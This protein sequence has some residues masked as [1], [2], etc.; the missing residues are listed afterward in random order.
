MSLKSLKLQ[1]MFALSLTLATVSGAQTPSPALLVLNK[2][3]RT[4][5]VVDPIS[6]RV[7]AQIP[8]DEDPHEV[9]ASADGKLAF[10]SNY[11]GTDH[12]LHT[13]SVVD[14]VA[15]KD[16]APIDL[17][18]LGAPHGM[19]FASD[20]ELYF[21]I[22][23]NQAIARYDLASHK[24]DWLLGLGQHRTHMIAVSHDLN[25]I[26]TSNVNSDTIS[27]IERD[28]GPNA[29]NETAI[30]VG[31]GPEGFDIS[32]DGGQLWAANSHDGTISVIDVNTK[33]VVETLAI[34]T[35]QA[36]RLKFTPDGKR[37]LIS[38]IHG[39]ELVVVDVAGKK[40]I[41]RFKLGSAA[42][43]ILIAPDGSRA[44]VA[45]TPDNEV[46][47]IDLR[48][49]EVTAHIETGRGPDGMAWAVR[50]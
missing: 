32:P 22:E 1:F 39:G 23:A 13:I 9:A 4:L 46:A 28:P 33:K 14:L 34:P 2:E 3:D 42:A 50:R 35:R 15:Q 18:P 45:L 31:K 8:A 24:I 17:G 47:I 21:T 27:I 12:S 6:L 41:K 38:D 16:L 30:A 49:L 7:V 20:N 36:N 5:T 37:V 48:T 19:A 29:W 25:R 40:E 10:I 11:G 43:G 26:F 44:F